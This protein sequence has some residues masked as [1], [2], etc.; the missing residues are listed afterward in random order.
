MSQSPDTLHTA[1]GGP[2]S[3]VIDDPFVAPLAGSPDGFVAH[4][5]VVRE[6]FVTMEDGTRM[7]ALQFSFA[8]DMTETAEK[9]ARGA[10]RGFFPRVQR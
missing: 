8:R 7:P 2:N 9:A 10:K 1:A 6:S 5:V 4:G 3:T